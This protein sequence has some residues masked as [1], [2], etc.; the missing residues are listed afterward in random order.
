MRTRT[1]S[2]IIIFPDILEI[3]YLDLTVTWY[4]KNKKGKTKKR[5]QTFKAYD[6][7]AKIVMEDGNFRQID[8]KY[9]IETKKG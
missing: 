8:I 7:G 4:E 5:N 3:N 9:G 1:K 2:H 6:L